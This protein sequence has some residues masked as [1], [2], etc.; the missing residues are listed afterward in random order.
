MIGNNEYLA[1]GHF[2]F[3][4]VIEFLRER[5]KLAVVVVGMAKA[6]L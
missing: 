4:D 1:K 5:A 6:C 3:G 2:G